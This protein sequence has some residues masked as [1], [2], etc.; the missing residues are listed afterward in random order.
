MNN[1]MFSTLLSHLHM[2]NYDPV[3]ECWSLMETGAVDWRGQLRALR[4]DGYE[5]FALIETHTDV[6]VHE[7]IPLEDG[8]ATDTTGLAPKE[9]NSL[10]NLEFVRAC[11][12]S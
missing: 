9:A 6:S 2:K 7:F 12:A 11:L 10:R 3:G 5:G 8:A 4:D 1:I